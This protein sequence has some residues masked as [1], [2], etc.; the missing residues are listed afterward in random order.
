MSKRITS[1]S[2][3]NEGRYQHL[4]SPNRHQR[5]FTGVKAVT[6]SP[7]RKPLSENPSSI[8]R[9]NNRQ[10]CREKKRQ[11]P[12]KSKHSSVKKQMQRNRNAEAY[13]MS[14]RLY[15]KNRRGNETPEEYKKRL[16]Y[17]RQ[18]AKKIRVA[19]M[20]TTKVETIKEAI[21]KAMKEGKEALHRTV[22]EKNSSQHRANVCIICDCFILGTDSIKY[23]KPCDIRKH[24]SRIGVE[25]Y[26]SYYKTTLHEDLVKH[27][28]VTGLE[29]MLLSPSSKMTTNGYVTCSH[30]FC[31][32]S[33]NNCN[34]VAPPKYSIAN[35]FVIGSIPPKAF[36]IGNGKYLDVEK[37]EDV[38]EVLRAM[39]APIRPY[40][41]IF[42]YSG[43]AHQCI[44]GH[45]SYF[46]LDQCDVSGVMN[47]IDPDNIGKTIYCMS[48]GRMTPRQKQI[49]RDRAKVD[50]NRYRNLLSWFINNGHPGYKGVTLP[51]DAPPKLIVLEDI[52]SPNNTDASVNEDKEKHVEVGTYYFSNAHDPTN[53]TSVYQTESQFALA[54]MS[55]STPTLLAIGGQ[56]A[57]S[58]EINVE[59]ILPF[60]FPYGIGGPRMNRR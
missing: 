57:K 34:K 10:R 52:E 50:T 24:K 15:K 26:Q 12:K 19:K 1:S 42:A 20:T 32:M 41:C 23:L 54:M 59:D 51:E 45:Y 4:V 38:N 2:S 21:D 9:R 47:C 29:G 3:S 6:P 18:Y 53:R 60:A 27:Y 22:N 39:I 25:S 35:G 5:Q 37:D 16:Q 17:Q 44:R 48:C 33:P 55:H 8:R 7:R 13:R 14:D 46:M 36:P 11:L 56:Y 43:G 31:G 30:C 28:E 40:G 49:I 58:N